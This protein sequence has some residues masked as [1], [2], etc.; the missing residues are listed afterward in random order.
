MG[1]NSLINMLVSIFIKTASYK[2]GDLS[3][4]FSAKANASYL[5]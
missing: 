4:R 5:I 3:I 1:S 2:E